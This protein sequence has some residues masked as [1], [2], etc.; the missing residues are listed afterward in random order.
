[1][2]RYDSGAL[3]LGFEIGIRRRHRHPAKQGDCLK[4]VV[5]HNG[6]ESRPDGKS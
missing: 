6:E 3:G 2:S 5:E 1:M 4:E